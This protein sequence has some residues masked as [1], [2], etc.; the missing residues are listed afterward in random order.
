MKH[1]NVTIDLK[2]NNVQGDIRRLIVDNLIVHTHNSKHEEGPNN[3]S[4]SPLSPSSSS[5][6]SPSP[7]SSSYHHNHGDHDE[8]QVTVEE[9]SGGIT[10]KRMCLSCSSLAHPS[11]INFVFSFA[12]S[13]FSVQLSLSRT[14]IH[15]RSTTPLS[16]PNNN[17]Q[18]QQRANPQC[19]KLM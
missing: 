11:S 13:L 8:Q 16:H 6:S 1:V 14:I 19:T 18:S 12:N 5:L 3:E 15:Y 4:T 10:N 2:S 9:L 17:N 7:S